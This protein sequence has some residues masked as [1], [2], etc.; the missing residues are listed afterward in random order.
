MKKKAPTC[1]S[2]IL[3][4]AGD[5]HELTMLTGT[6]VRLTKRA[7]RTENETTKKKLKH[8]QRLT[9]RQSRVKLNR[10][11]IPLNE[12]ELWKLCH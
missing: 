9:A 1:E 3:A 10:P 2:L 4:H 6:G 7:S 5:V 12:P 11:Y 8:Q